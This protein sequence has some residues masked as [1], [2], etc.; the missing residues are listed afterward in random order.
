MDYTLCKVACRIELHSQFDGNLCGSRY[1]VTQ[2]TAVSFFSTLF[3]LH[4]HHQFYSFLSAI[5]FLL[6]ALLMYTFTGYTK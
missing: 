3:F 5:L 1:D 4:C 2:L 6:L